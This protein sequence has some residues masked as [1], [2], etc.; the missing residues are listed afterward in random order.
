MNR[1]LHIRFVLFKR[2]LCWALKELVE[3]VGQLQF[4]RRWCLK[5]EESNDV[6]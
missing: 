2:N 3:I 4:R 6:T 5:S 1:F